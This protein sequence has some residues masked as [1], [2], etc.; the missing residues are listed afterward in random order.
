MQLDADTHEWHVSRIEVLQ[1]ERHLLSTQVGALSTAR[2]AQDAHIVSLSKDAEAA[3]VQCKALA[4]A[5][6]E[7]SAKA[8]RVSLLESRNEQLEKLML[9]ATAAREA[10]GKEVG[11]RDTEVHA[12]QQRIHMLQEEALSHREQVHKANAATATLRMKLEDANARLSALETSELRLT[13]RVHQLQEQ[14]AKLAGQLAAA[15]TARDNTA[16]VLEEAQRHGN[17]HAERAATAL[18]AARKATEALERGTRDRAA[19]ARVCQDHDV[20]MIEEMLSMRV[21]RI[22]THTHTHT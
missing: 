14:A 2:E 4:A 19:A 9:E 17:K 1:R 20:S 18:E 22:R 6:T 3:M 12:C 16:E 10:L 7:L 21:C 8:Q 5:I 11:I 13:E 15:E